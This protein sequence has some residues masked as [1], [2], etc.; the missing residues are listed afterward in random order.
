MVST[1]EANAMAEVIHF[2][3]GIQQKDIDKIPKKF[4]KYLNDNA[5]KDYE[6]TFDYTK[7]LKD[8]DLLEETRGIIAMICYNYWCNSISEKE[9][10]V[11]KLC[12]NEEK[13]EEELREKYNPDEIFNKDEYVNEYYNYAEDDKV[14][15]LSMVKYKESFFVKFKH[16]FLK[17]FHKNV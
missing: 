1:K 10:Y 4:M 12:E 7:P 2:L 3:K 17:L 13:H 9:E 16:F 8:L 6:C 15:T 11:K 5:S 14:N